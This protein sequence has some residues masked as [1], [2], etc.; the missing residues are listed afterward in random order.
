ME[1]EK[2]LKIIHLKDGNFKVIEKKD[3]RNPV[4]PILILD[5]S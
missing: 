1:Q 5:I 3:K 2:N 4:K